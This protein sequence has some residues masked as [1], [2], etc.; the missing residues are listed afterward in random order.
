M[1]G[2]R[3]EK[4]DN[5]KMRLIDAAEAQIAAEGLVG[6]KARV[7][8][9]AAGCALGALYTAFED[10]DR[11]ILHVNSRTLARL[12]AALEV[13]CPAGQ[14]PKQAL[15]ALAQGYVGFALQNYRLWAALFS[16]HLPAG[17]EAPEWHIKDHAVLIAQI[18]RPLSQLRPDLNPTALQQRARTVFSAVHGVVAMAVTGRYVTT[19][20]QDLPGEVAAIVDALTRGLAD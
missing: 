3:E 19:P 12:G 5:L 11:L 17:V 18:I 8:T 1:A 10:L 20:Q 6:L 14:G 4:R 16:H 7:V 9:A 15:A 2:L 13:A